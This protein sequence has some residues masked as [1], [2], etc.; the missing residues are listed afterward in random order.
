M[1]SF[2]PEFSGTDTTFETVLI[3]NNLIRWA[4]YLNKS[5]GHEQ[6]NMKTNKTYRTMTNAEVKKAAKSEVKAINSNPTYLMRRMNKIGQGKDTDLSDLKKA[7]EVSVIG[8][9][10]L[11][12]RLEEAFGCGGFWWG[13]LMARQGMLL[14]SCKEVKDDL[15]EGGSDFAPLYQRDGF[16]WTE[17]IDGKLY[18]FKAAASW[19]YENIVSSASMWLRFAEARAKASGQLYSWMQA[20]K[21][22]KK[23]ASK[24]SKKSEKKQSTLERAALQLMQSFSKGEINSKELKKGLKELEAKAA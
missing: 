1:F 6:M 24:T 20:R 15:S 21:D 18:S 19:S 14:T 9:V 17:V 22:A 16:V 3:I 12:N 13:S 7:Q 8:I 4:R 2:A 11:Y 23:K 5:Q 10:E